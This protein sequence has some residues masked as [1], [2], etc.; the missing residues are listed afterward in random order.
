MEAVHL[1]GH[2]PGQ[3]GYYDH[4][5]HTIFIGDTSGIGGAQPGEPYGE[6]CRV[7]ALRN[8]LKKLQPRF[9]EI[10]GVFPGHGMLDQSSVTLQ[11]L[12]D[13]AEAVIAHPDRY[14]SRREFVRNGKTVV[15]YTKNI[16]Q[17]SAIRYKPENV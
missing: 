5:N 13:A 15:T 11:Y 9:S 8:A 14:D 6:Y 12:L 17:G 16:Y 10:Q 3:C 7:T 4:H 2:T 1:P